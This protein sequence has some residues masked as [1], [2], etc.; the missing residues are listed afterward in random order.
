M[1][2]AMSAM[3]PV[4]SADTELEMDVER[5]VD[6]LDGIKGLSPVRVNGLRPALKR[7]RLAKVELDDAADVVDKKSDQGTTPTGKESARLKVAQGEYADATAALSEMHMELM[8][9][10]HEQINKLLKDSR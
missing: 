2:I 10:I 5:I 6:F 4:T 7:M 8:K 3:R 9:D 1:K